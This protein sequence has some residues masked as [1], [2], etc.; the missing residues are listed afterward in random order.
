MSTKH[1]SESF[2][3][4]IFTKSYSRIFLCRWFIIK[5]KIKEWYPAAAARE[6]RPSRAP[7][8]C[9]GAAVRCWPWSGGTKQELLRPWPRICAPGVEL[10]PSGP[11]PAHGAAVG[12]RTLARMEWEREGQKCTW[13]NEWRVV[14]RYRERMDRSAGRMWWRATAS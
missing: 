7:G 11:T 4:T 6:Q 13:E 2:L 12:A 10:L 8:P 1:T 14:E 3:L 5:I 9:R